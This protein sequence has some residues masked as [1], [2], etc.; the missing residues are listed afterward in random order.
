MI[1]D[2]SKM[3]DLNNRTDDYYDELDTFMMQTSPSNER[4]PIAAAAHIDDTKFVAEQAQGDAEQ[5]MNGVAHVEP[6]VIEDGATESATA[7]QQLPEGILN[8]GDEQRAM[9]VAQLD[10][11][12]DYLFA[13]RPHLAVRCKQPLSPHHKKI[14]TRVYSKEQRNELIAEVTLANSI[15]YLCWYGL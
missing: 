6:E 14:L 1:G 3:N 9:I 4:A 7:A 5:H 12:L 13:I 2:Y 8:Y 11:E 10:E 15:G